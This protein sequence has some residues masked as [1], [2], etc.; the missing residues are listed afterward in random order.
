[1]GSKAPYRPSDLEVG[2]EN[3]EGKLYHVR[4]AL[5]NGALTKEGKP[6][7][8]LATTRPETLFGDVAVAVHPKDPRYQGLEGAFVRVPLLDKPVPILYDEAVD[9][10]LARVA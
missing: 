9:A 8:L 3:R 10:N 6:Y 4:Y 1:M 5:E 7:L 2:H